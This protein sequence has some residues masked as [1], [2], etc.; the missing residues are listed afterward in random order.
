MCDTY[1]S[2]R[3]GAAT[4]HSHHVAATYVQLEQITLRPLRPR[5]CAPSL[6]SAKGK[7]ELWRVAE[8]KYVHPIAPTDYFAVLKGLL[9][10]LLLNVT[11][12]LTFLK[13]F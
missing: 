12:R 9:V 4:T 3:A 13:L 8:S 1:I 5:N 10:P 7:G 2:S 11:S 6:D